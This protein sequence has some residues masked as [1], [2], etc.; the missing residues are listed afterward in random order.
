MSRRPQDKGRVA[1][2][3]SLKYWNA[4]AGQSAERIVKHGNHDQGDVSHME[5]HGLQGLMEVKNHD[6]SPSDSEL[7]EWRRQTEAER[8]NAGKDWA[9]LWYHRPRCN[10]EDH[11]ARTFGRNWCDLTVDSYHAIAGIGRVP[12]E[13]LA[14]RWVTITID[15]CMRLVTGYI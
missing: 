5:A 8:V 4:C 14:R 2:T 1:E 10:I 3:A 6:H 9:V 12:D 13:A 11:E 7:E 15:E